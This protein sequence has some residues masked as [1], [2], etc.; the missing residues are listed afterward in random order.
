[1]SDQVNPED[2]DDIMIVIGEKG[3]LT[4]ENA[5]EAA[6]GVALACT[7][8]T[9]ADVS[10]F[11]SGYDDDP[12]E[13]WEIFETRFYIWMFVEALEIQSPSVAVT[14]QSRLTSDSIKWKRMYRV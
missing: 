1:M 5:F 11:I 3:E 14:I 12:R 8:N 2:Y 4:P 10:L 6:K 9:K 7:I 13:L